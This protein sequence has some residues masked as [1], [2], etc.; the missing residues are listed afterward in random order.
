[1]YLLHNCQITYIES[2]LKVKNINYYTTITYILDF[3]TFEEYR[4]RLLL[5]CSKQD[6]TISVKHS[7]HNSNYSHP[8]S[9]QSQSQPLQL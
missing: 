5:P 2:H 6:H 1:M 4:E 9:S 3:K 7:S 8:Q